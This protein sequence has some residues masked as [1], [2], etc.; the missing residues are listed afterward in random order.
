MWP[1]SF[2]AAMANFACS[3][4]GMS[5]RTRPTDLATIVRAACGA[6][7]RRR[8]PGLVVRIPHTPSTL[9]FD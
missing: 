7:G 4:S 8:H 1:A 9:A 5:R 3:I 6:V 2:G